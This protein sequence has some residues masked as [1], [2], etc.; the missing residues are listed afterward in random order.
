MGTASSRDAR[1]TQFASASVEGSEQRMNGAITMGS[2]SVYQGYWPVMKPFE[3]YT[4]EGQ[5]KPATTRTR[6]STVERRSK[7]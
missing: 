3:A 5:D 1:Q 2:L 4:V 6:A 7:E